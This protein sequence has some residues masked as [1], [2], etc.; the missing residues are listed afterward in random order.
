MANGIEEHIGARLKRR[1]IAQNMTASDLAMKLRI[2]CAVLASI[3]TGRRRLSAFELSQCARAL[4]TTVSYLVADFVRD[5][6]LMIATT[7]EPHTVAD[8]GTRPVT[9]IPVERR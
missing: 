7:A 4:G 2:E 6:N 9:V 5:Q 3:E 1:R 8:A